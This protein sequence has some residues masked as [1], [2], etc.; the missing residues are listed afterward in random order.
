MSDHKVEVVPVIMEKHPNADSLSVVRIFDAYTCVVRTQD[1]LGIDKAAYIPPDSIVPDTEE[2]T[3]LDGRRRIKAKSLRGIVSQGLLVP[4]PKGSNIGDDVAE[5]MGIVHYE[6]QVQCNQG[7][8]EK[9][10]PPQPGI[11][12]DIESWYKFRSVFDSFPGV[13]VT[14]TEKIHGTNSRFTYQEGRM[15]AASHKFWRKPGVDNVYWKAMSNNPWIE[16]YCR[17][18]P[19]AVL[20]GEIFGMGIQKDYTYDCRQGDPLK[21]RMFDVYEA[22]KFISWSEELINSGSDRIVPVLYY[23][24]YSHEIV[25]K[26]ING[27]STIAGHI[28]EGV[29]IKPTVELW[30]QKIGRVIL[31][32]VSPQYLEKDKN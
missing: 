13:N 30:H 20:Y 14:I 21:F 16:A 25:E 7:E 8:Q 27:K 23:G 9:F 18:N 32:A 6:P 12:Y 15:W 31:K 19:N 24:P 17:L 4:A 11:F 22:G 2:F 3:F 26:Y 28:R 29:V 1:W 5:L 10:G